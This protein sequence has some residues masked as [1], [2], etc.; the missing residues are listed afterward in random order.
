MVGN[1]M[2][3]VKVVFVL[4][5]TFSLQAFAS[6]QDEIDHL[7]SYVESSGCQYERNGSM[8]TSQEA[9]E[10]IKKKYAYFS[11]DIHSTE[12]FIQYSATKSRLSGKY[13]K[14]HCPNNMP[15]KS[16]EWLLMELQ[17]YRASNQ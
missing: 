12:D 5:S 3:L 14:I 6:T 7:L 11:D 1:S 8:H 15:V 9:V 10:H 17:A 2:N 13:Y 16:Q 4:L